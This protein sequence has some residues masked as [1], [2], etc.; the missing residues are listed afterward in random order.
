MLIS[1]VIRI[2]TGK[3]VLVAVF[4]FVLRACSLLPTVEMLTFLLL[5][6]LWNT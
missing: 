3:D 2:L 5:Q 1:L 6:L 4:G